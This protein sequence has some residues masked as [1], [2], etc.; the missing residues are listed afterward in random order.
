MAKDLDTE[1][2]KVRLALQATHLPTSIDLLGSEFA[3][4]G[5][6]GV[7][8]CGAGGALSFGRRRA[9]AGAE[10]GGQD[11]G[12]R[13]RGRWGACLILALHMEGV[14]EITVPQYHTE[15]HHHPLAVREVRRIL[16]E[17]LANLPPGFVVPVRAVSQGGP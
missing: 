8:A 10:L 11:A 3:G 12:V 7:A 1:N 16:Y 15:V 9:A 14:S 2:P 17:H 5:V 4:P 6:V 13:G